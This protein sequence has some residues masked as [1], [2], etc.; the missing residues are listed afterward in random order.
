LRTTLSR[1]Q[2][3]RGQEQPLGQKSSGRSSFWHRN[4]HG[5]LFLLPWF[6]GILVFS[7]IPIIWSLYLAF[8]NYDLFTT[9]NWVGLRNFTH[10]AQNPRYLKAL[11]VT[12]QYVLI[13]VPL[14]LLTA[15]SLA[16]LLNRGVPGLPLFRAIFYVP[17]LLGGSVAIA[18]LWRRLFGVDGVLNQ[19]LGFLGVTFDRPISWVS[20]PNYALYTLILLLIWAF[21]SPMIIFLAGLKQIPTDLY[22]SASIDGATVVSS[23]F[24][25][26]LPLL[27]PVIFFNLVMQIIS[28]FQAFT[29]AFIVAGGSSGGPLDSL[30]FYTLYLYFLG[31]VEFRMGYAAAMAWV[32]LLIILAFTALLFFSA[33]WWV[34]Y[35]DE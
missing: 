21:G 4:K 32:L 27:T 22:E 9:P 19:V 1:L 23:F 5:Y 20:D 2:L 25:I 3:G 30:L 17:S 7:A 28:A 8:T 24:Y 10:M 13:G 34:Y 26:T 14:Q 12:F 18:L 11:E 35:R 15:L 33:R 16:L 31:F 6:I 29:P